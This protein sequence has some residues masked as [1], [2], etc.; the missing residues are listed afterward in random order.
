M[1]LHSVVSPEFIFPYD[2]AVNSVS[3]IKYGYKEKVNGSV[4]LFSTNPFDYI[5]GKYLELNQINKEVKFFGG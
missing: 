1:L 3:L 5:N 2:T 4:H